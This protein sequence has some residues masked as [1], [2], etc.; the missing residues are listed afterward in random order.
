MRKIKIPPRRRQE[1]RNGYFF[2]LPSL[3][4]TSHFLFFPSS[5]KTGM[6]ERFQPDHGLSMKLAD[7]GFCDVENGADFFHREF[8]KIIE[9]ENQSLTFR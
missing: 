1:E 4:L 8:F 3:R 9:R 2:S 6:K 5:R 7:T